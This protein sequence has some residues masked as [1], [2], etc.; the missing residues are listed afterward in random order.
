MLTALEKD[1]LRQKTVFQQIV[2]M[3]LIGVA[4][5]VLH[6][7]PSELSFGSEDQNITDP[8]QKETAQKEMHE[9][10]HRLATTVINTKD[11]KVQ[12]ASNSIASRIAEEVAENQPQYSDMVETSLRKI[13]TGINLSETEYNLIE[14]IIHNLI[15]DG[16]S[17]LA[18][19]N[20]HVKPFNNV[21]A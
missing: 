5:D 14:A 1:L 17:A 2:R 18:G 20:V 9:Y 4:T 8:V 12:E 19:Y 21:I 7:I 10:R 3:E 16:F 13:L 6:E 15:I 11:G